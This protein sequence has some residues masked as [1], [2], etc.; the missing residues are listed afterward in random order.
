[1]KKFSDPRH[2]TRRLAV[3]LIFS[4]QNSQDPRYKEITKDEIR[5]AISELEVK[6]YEKDFLNEILAGVQEKSEEIIEDI[7]KHSTGWEIEKIY[8]TDLAVLTVAI[9]EIKYSKKTPFKVVADEAVELAKEFG[10]KD[11]SKFV[12]GILSGVIRESG[13]QNG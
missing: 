6:S 5:T 2:Q 3:S 4:E 12:N 13:E 7:K 8:R 11:S 1:M 10:E 9:W